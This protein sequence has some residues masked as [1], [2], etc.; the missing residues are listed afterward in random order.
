MPLFLCVCSHQNQ[1]VPLRLLSHLRLSHQTLSFYGKIVS[2]SFLEIGFT[3][4]DSVR[5]CDEQVILPLTW[6]QLK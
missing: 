3:L 4:K 2:H 1:S 5:V 6:R